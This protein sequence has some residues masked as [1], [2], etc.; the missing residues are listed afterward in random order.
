[1]LVKFITSCHILGYQE[2]N[3]NFVNIRAYFYLGT[4]IK[5][6]LD[7]NNINPFLQPPVV[8]FFVKNISTPSFGPRSTELQNFS[9]V[10]LTISTI[11]YA[12]HST[13]ELAHNYI[14]RT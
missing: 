14:Q 9:F 2:K 1:M 13:E 6:S 7:V 4:E 12:G 3:F 5:I 8:F 10:R 11:F